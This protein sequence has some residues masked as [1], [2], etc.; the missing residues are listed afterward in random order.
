MQDRDYIG[1]SYG[2][3]RDKPNHVL[4]VEINGSNSYY[5]YFV[6]QNVLAKDGR[7]GS[8]FAITLRI[9]RYYADVKNIYNLL[10][11][12]YNKF[13]LNK[14][15]KNNGVSMSYLIED[16]NQENDYLLSL[17]R[18]II[19][20]LNQFSSNTDLIALTGFPPQV[21]FTEEICLSDCDSNKIVQKIRTNGAVLISPH[22]ESIATK[23]IL[24]TKDEE[25]QRIKED[26]QITINNI[27]AQYSETERTISILK[28]NLSLEQEKCNGLKIS[29]E[30]SVK[31]I[32][33]L[34]KLNKS[35]KQLQ[36]ELK[37]KTDKL[38]KIEQ[39]LPKITATVK[40]LS[41]TFNGNVLSGDNC[42]IIQRKS[43]QPRKFKVNPII[44][45]SISFINT[46][47]LIFIAL[48]ILLP[49]S[50]TDKKSQGLADSQNRIQSLESNLVKKEQ[51]LK[52]LQEYTNA[53]FAEAYID[54]DKFT[55]KKTYLNKGES[56]K[57]SLLKVGSFE[58]DSGL[59]LN[60]KGEVKAK[61]KGTYQIHCVVGDKIV[62]SR[63][64]EVR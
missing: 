59:T 32:T 30:D 31:Q 10:D 46:L 56:S 17:E 45:F 29:L 21:R 38:V 36:D 18:E 27:R 44:S 63:T 43:P 5:T 14:I 58:V 16:F 25:I 22:F 23:S 62:K 50:C 57:F 35:G 64:I 33:N 1:L 55:N 13:I 39:I 41:S 40:E 47:L 48:I 12:A 20:Y 8:Y 2:K 28:N 54:I 26:S 60:E 34:E 11:A 4:S 49:K 15:I 61:D 6:G 9:N 52:K 3:Y 24:K 53:I 19:N 42:D 7:P 37:K 51:E